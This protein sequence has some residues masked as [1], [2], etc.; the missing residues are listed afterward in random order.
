MLI[1]NVQITLMCFMV[2]LCL[3]VNA[4]ETDLTDDAHLWNIIQKDTFPYLRS[5]EA[6][7]KVADASLMLMEFSK[8]RN[9]NAYPMQVV[10]AYYYNLLANR[11]NIADSIA[12]TAQNSQDKYIYNNL[13]GHIALRNII[14]CFGIQSEACD[15]IIK[16]TLPILEHAA[17]KSE[18]MPP[19]Q[20]KWIKDMIQDSLKQPK[21][22]IELILAN[23]G[24]NEQISPSWEGGILRFSIQPGKENLLISDGPRKPLQAYELDSSGR[25]INISSHSGLDSFPGG[26]LI[27]NIDYNIDGYD[28]LMILRKS[29]SANS[30]VTY[31]PLLLKN[32]GNGCFTEVS[33]EAGLR[34]QRRTNCACWGDINQDGLPD[35]F[36]GHEYSPSFWMIQNQDGIFENKAYSLNVITKKKN[37][38]DCFISDFN[39]DGLND[40]L[41]SYRNDSNEIFIQQRVNDEFSVFYEKSSQYDIKLP[42]LSNMILPFNFASDSSHEFIIQTDLMA[43]QEITADIMNFSDTIDFEP[44]FIYN[45]QNDSVFQSIAEASVSLF[46]AGIFIE[47]PFSIDLIAGGGKNTESIYPMFHYKISDKGHITS[48]SLPENWPLYVHSMTAYPDSLDQPILIVKGGGAYPFMVNRLVSYQI[49]MPEP[50]RFVRLFNFGKVKIGSEVKFDYITQSGKTLHLTRNVRTPDSRGFSALQEWIWVPEGDLVRNIKLSEKDLPET[51]EPTK[52]I[53]ENNP[54]K[55]KKEKKK[56]KK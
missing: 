56:S 27:Y 51:A 29:S 8:E 45:I 6:T 14:P 12:S 41:L 26:H 31:H 2:I 30:P 38:L 18:I 49:R 53:Q 33:K 5:H 20:W 10:Q 23:D 3:K 47:H 43:Q 1:K 32:D 55:S 40:L 46:K 37:I 17:L 25:W 36:I 7:Q 34:Y 28:D 35:V 52:A 54:E 22:N 48:V 21:S 11:L 42:V 13:S 39:Q 44:S 4:Q 15:S 16:S 9:K 24:L 50:G 19:G